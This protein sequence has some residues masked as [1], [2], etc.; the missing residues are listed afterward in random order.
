MTPAQVALNQRQIDQAYGTSGLAESFQ[1]M[2]DELRPKWEARIAREDAARAAWITALGRSQGFK[3]AKPLTVDDYRRRVIAFDVADLMADDWFI[4]EAAASES[5]A[6][7]QMSRKF[8]P[9]YAIWHE[10]D[11][12][13]RFK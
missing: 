8:D 7:H 12:Q 5:R 10:I 4:Y 13:R 9:D 3:P 1:A 6:L 11:A 2:V